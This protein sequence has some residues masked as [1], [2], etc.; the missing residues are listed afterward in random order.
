M[1]II[2][3]NTLCTPTCRYKL[4]AECIA[5]AGPIPNAALHVFSICTVFIGVGRDLLTSFL[6]T[7]VTFSV[8]SCMINCLNA[9]ATLLSNMR[10]LSHSNLTGGKPDFLT[11]GLRIQYGSGVN[12]WMMTWRSTQK[13]NVGVWHGP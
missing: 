5:D 1:Y 12:V 13:P 11:S 10:P 3:S 4:S 6:T 9:P 8:P 7:L 2:H